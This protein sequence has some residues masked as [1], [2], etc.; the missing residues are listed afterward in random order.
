MRDML[1]IEPDMTI[2]R[3]LTRIRMPLDLMARTYADALRAAGLPE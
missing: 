1:A 3:L 2:S